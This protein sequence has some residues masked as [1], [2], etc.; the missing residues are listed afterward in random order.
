MNDGIRT[1]AR[2]FTVPDAAATLQSPRCFPRDSN[3][4]RAVLQT[5]VLP[6]ELEKHGGAPG[7]TARELHDG[8]TRC[9]STTH[10]RWIH[11]NR[12]TWPKPCPFHG[13]PPEN[14][15]QARVLPRPCNYHYTSRADGPRLAAGATEP[16]LGL[17]PRTYGLQNRCAAVAPGRRG[18]DFQGSRT[19]V[20]NSLPVYLRQHRIPQ[21]PLRSRTRDSDPVLHFT[22]VLR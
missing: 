10:N 14:R 7:L 8:T 9:P 1:R 2:G 3:S 20:A 17:E 15:T 5:A 16:T 21:L 6:L 18:R 13:A 4:R 11:T 22:K 19:L 12:H